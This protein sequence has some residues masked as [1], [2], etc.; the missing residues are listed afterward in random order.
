MSCD[1]WILARSEGDEIV[2]Q[3][4]QA[5]AEHIPVSL[6]AFRNRFLAQPDEEAEEGAESALGL[7]DGEDFLPPE[8][9]SP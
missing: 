4:D 2:F 3:L 7:D 6:G 1:E 8:E 5:L 9:E